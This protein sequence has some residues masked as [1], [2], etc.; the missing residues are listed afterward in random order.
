MNASLSAMCTVG[1]EPHTDASHG[2]VGSVCART[3]HTR[4][5]AQPRACLAPA[6]PLNLKICSEAA[7][8]SAFPRQ[9]IAA[10][11]AAAMP[12][13]TA[14]PLRHNPEDQSFRVQSESD[15]DAGSSEDRCFIPEISVDNEE[16]PELST[17]RV[18]TKDFPGQFRCDH[19]AL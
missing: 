4:I 19:M 18:T 6:R 14:Q 17:I 15:R 5:A 11:P 9:R 12:A 1:P 8:S 10:A 2:R 16:H 13:G 7:E 3:V